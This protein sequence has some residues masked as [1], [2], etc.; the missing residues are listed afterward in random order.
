M[1]K[2]L[3]RGKTDS[4]RYVPSEHHINSS[5]HIN[6]LV[7]DVRFRSPDTEEK[8]KSFYRTGPLL[9]SMRVYNDNNVHA[10]FL[11][12]SVLDTKKRISIRCFPTPFFSYHQ[13]G[14]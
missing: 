1:G 6:E 4:K 13:N 7:L 11:E 8:R 9:C 12:V 10:G 14:T 3:T 2:K 5:T